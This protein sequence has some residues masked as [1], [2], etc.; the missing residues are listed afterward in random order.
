TPTGEILPFK[1][2]AFHIAIAAG[3]A[4]FPVVVQ[5]AYELSPKGTIVSHPGTIRLHFLAPIPTDGLGSDSASIHSLADQ[6][7]TAMAAAYAEM[8]TRA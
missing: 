2:G 6:V 3:A 1:M 5:G 7:R 4:V 8:R